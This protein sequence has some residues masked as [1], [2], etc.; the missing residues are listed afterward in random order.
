MSLRSTQKVTHSLP[1]SVSDEQARLE[2][3]LEL[4]EGLE[5]ISLGSVAILL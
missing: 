4:F 3:W 2:V 1:C 5:E